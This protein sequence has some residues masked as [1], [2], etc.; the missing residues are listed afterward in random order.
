[1]TFNSV[2][3]ASGTTLHF[4]ADPAREKLCRLDR[5]YQPRDELTLVIDYHTNGHA[6][7][8]GLQGFGRGLTYVKP[9][10]DD[11]FNGGK[12]GR[13]VR[14]SLITTGFLCYDHPNDFTTTELFA[15]VEKP[16]MVI[17][18]GR[19]LNVRD[20][21]TARA[22][23]LKIEA[24]HASYLT[25]IVVGE[26]TPIEQDYAGIPVISYVYPDEVEAGKVTV[27]RMAGM[28]KFFRRRPALNIHMRNTRRR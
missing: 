9:N 23:S 7:G 4:Q 12:S 19:L 26:Y 5:A 13:R 3:L 18:N 24:A 25:S 21:R 16:L 2:K 8:G 14:R 28:V 10:E 15:I 6:K 27:K 17:S 11:P 20:N 22:L 1:M